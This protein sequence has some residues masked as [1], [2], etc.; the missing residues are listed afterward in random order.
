MSDSIPT[1]QYPAVRVVQAGVVRS[2]SMWSFNIVRRLLE[3][4]PPERHVSWQWAEGPELD[5]VV[6]TTLGSDHHVI[7]CHEESGGF[8]PAL[9]AH[10]VNGIVFSLRDPMASLASCM[11]QFVTREPFCH[12]WNFEVALGHIEGGLQLARRVAGRPEVVFV[13]LH[14]DGEAASLQRIVEFMDLTL[15]PEV[16]DS[17]REQ[18]TFSEMRERSARIAEQ[19]PEALM[20]GINDPVTFMHANHVDKGTGRDWRSEL[21]AEQIDV[22]TER[23]APYADLMSSGAEAPKLSWGGKPGFSAA[24]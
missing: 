21:T 4:A 23:F 14:R 3:L 9:D 6:W 18:F 13:D 2:G 17:V 15:A 11:E 24:A 10:F 12:H 19:P 5:S 8:I 7:K 1:P 20:N 16:V 22:A